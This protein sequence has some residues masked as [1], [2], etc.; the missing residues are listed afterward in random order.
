M[1][2]DF[3]ARREHSDKGAATV[4]RSYPSHFLVLMDSLSLD[5]RASRL[6]ISLYDVDCRSSH[7]L[8]HFAFVHHVQCSVYR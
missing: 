5:L 3:G 2:L 7:V 1:L 8:L 4:D 6:S